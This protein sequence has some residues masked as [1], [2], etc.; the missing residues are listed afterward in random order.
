MNSEDKWR[1]SALA[2]ISN[3]NKLVTELKTNERLRAL[4][5]LSR[6]ISIVITEINAEMESLIPEAESILIEKNQFSNSRDKLDR[7]LQR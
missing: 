2:L 7:F 4:T 3:Q 1:I 5:I 6:N